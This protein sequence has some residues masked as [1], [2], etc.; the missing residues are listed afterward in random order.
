MVPDFDIAIVGSGFAGTLLAMAAKRSGRSVILLERGRHPRF[1][2]GESSTPLTNLLLEEIAREFG[3][4]ELLPLSKWGTWRRHYPEVACGLKR[5]F[6]F[7]HHQPGQAFRSR[8]DRS[9][10]LLVAASPRDEIA[11]THWYRADFDHLLLR[12]A[13]AHGV[14]YVDQVELSSVDFTGAAVRL[15]GMRRGRALTVRARFVVDASGPRGFLFRAL[16]LREDLVGPLPQTEALFSHFGDVARLDE[17]GLHT[18]TTPAPYPVDDAAVH[19]VFAGG[20]IWVLRFNNGLT[21]AGVAAESGFAETLRLGS[22]SPGWERLM[23]RFPTIREQ[24]RTAK[25]QMEFRHLPRLSFAVEQASGLRWALLPSA[26]GFV[27]PLLSTGFP[28]TLV[29]VQRL[30]RI[31]RDDWE[32][33]RAPERLAA[34]GLQT[35]RERVAVE[36]LT[37]ALYAAMGDFEVFAPLTFLYFA[38]A[39]FSE[40]ARRLDKPELAQAFL[41]CD[42]PVFAGMVQACCDDVLQRKGILTDSEKVELRCRIDAAIGP[43][44]CLGLADGSRRNWFPAQAADLLAAAGK[45]GVAESAIRELLRRSGFRDADGEGL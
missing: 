31:F 7:L 1:A 14:E 8:E 32:T 44:D 40:T 15:D 4:P 36:R 33:P 29:G 24:F 9:N 17:S 45:F 2:I 25:S 22:G 6:T 19:H 39:G 5:G 23:E 28:L 13:Q 38:A 34:Y 18:S 37:A 12:M 21:S 11:D 26:A 43:I 30:A 27:D 10:E 42:A 20:W 16:K 3:L 35:R 41:L